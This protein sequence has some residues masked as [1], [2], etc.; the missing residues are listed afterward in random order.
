MIGAPVL[1]FLRNLITRAANPQSSWT[2]TSRN[3]DHGTVRLRLERGTEV[4]SAVLN[5]NDPSNSKLAN[6]RLGDVV[7][8]DVQN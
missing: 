1:Q 6:A 3:E 8:P 7:V 4:M 2:V 5:V